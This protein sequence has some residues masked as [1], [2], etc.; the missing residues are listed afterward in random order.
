MEQGKH[1]NERK[2]IGKELIKLHYNLLSTSFQAGMKKAEREL[3]RNP[4]ELGIFQD[5]CTTDLTPI[6]TLPL[7]PVYSNRVNLTI[8]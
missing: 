1:S 5:I 7:H 2:I 3:K 8:Q 4:T 6:C